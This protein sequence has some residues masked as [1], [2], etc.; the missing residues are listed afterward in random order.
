M[1][2]ED[3]KRLK[4]K[5]PEKPGILGRDKY[6]NSAVLIPLVLIHRQ[7]H[8]LF[9]KRAAGI[10]QGGEVCFPGGGFDPRIDL[11]FRQSAI[12]ETCEELGIPEEKITIEGRLDTV[13]SNMGVLVEPYI[14]RLKIEGMDELSL[15]KLEVEAVFTLPVAYFK[16][17]LPDEYQVRLMAEPYF[18]KDGNKIELLPSERLGLPRKYHQ[19]WGGKQ[20]RVFV[21]ETP[22]GTIWGI[23]AELIH[24]V[25]KYC[26]Q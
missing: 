11:D 10:R 24:E 26:K 21:Y 5:L 1:K 23:T 8:F 18:F 20:N 22:Q 25:I 16:E 19:A 13:V 12:R 7:Y 2:E 6:F 9:Q 15:N 17:N 4:S 3:L 14:G